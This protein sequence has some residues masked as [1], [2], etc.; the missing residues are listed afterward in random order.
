MDALP[1]EL[2]IKEITLNTEV[3]GIRGFT[4]IGESGQAD[5]SQPFYPFGPTGER[6]SRL[7]FGHEEAALK[8][9][10]DNLSR[11]RLETLQ[12]ELAELKD[13]FNSAKDMDETARKRLQAD[14]RELRHGKTGR[15]KQLHRPLRM[16]GREPLA[17][18]R[19]LS[20]TAVPYGRD[21]QAD[22]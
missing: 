13:T 19:R 4:L 8:K 2:Y 9:E 6:G 14:I 11:E 12:K 21:R 20:A 15:R 10:T 16:A 7:V 18:M 22:G 5:P 3:E 17:R 1:H